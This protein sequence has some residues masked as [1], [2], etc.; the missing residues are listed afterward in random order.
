MS[1]RMYTHLIYCGLLIVIV[2]YLVRY[3]GNLCQLLNSSIFNREPRA[4]LD[5]EQ[6]Q[7]LSMELGKVRSRSVS[8]PFI[9][10]VFLENRQF[11]WETC[12][13]DSR[14]P[15]IVMINGDNMVINGDNMVIMW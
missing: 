3:A 14:W 15:F 10:D 9:V 2:Q 5:Q 4:S 13:N 7:R 11:V 8:I 1:I 6:L 12:R